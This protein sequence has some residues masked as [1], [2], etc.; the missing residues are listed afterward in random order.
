MYKNREKTVAEGVMGFVTAL[1]NDHHADKEVVLTHLQKMI[2]VELNLIQGND[3][4][5][6]K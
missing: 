6:N 3:P 5:R 1:T 2:K 4:N